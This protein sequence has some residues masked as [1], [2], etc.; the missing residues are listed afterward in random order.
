MNYQLH[1]NKLI[2]RAKHRVLEDYS[3]KHHIVPRCMGGSDD[4]NNLVSL[5]PEEHY[6]AHQLLVKIFPN[7]SKLINAA[8]MMIPNRPSNKLYGWLRKKFAESQSI[9]QTGSG[10]SQF[11]TRWIHNINLKESKRIKIIDLLPDG[12]VEGRKIKFDL[13]IIN[14]K[15]CDKKFERIEGVYCSEI[16]KRH[17]RSEAI[18]IIDNNLED[19]LLYYINVR[20]I[21]KTLIQFGVKGHRAGN[22]YFSEILKEKNLYVRPRTTK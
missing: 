17:D 16:C 5:T 18:K 15:H 9:N 6:V 7:N 1:Y 4:H 11:G 19:M 21:D 10:N 13:N 12:W 8:V 14:C 3:E 2:D 20:S 22:K